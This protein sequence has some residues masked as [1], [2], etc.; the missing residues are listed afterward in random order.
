MLC[1]R[2][3]LPFDKTMQIVLTNLG[4]RSKLNAH[5]HSI[6]L[7][8]HDMIVLKTGFPEF[9]Q[10]TGEVTKPNQDI[11][12]PDKLCRQTR[13]VNYPEVSRTFNLNNPPSQDV[14]LL[15]YGGYTVVRI[16]TS[17]PGN[18]FLH[19]HQTI[20]LLEGMAAVVRVAPEKVKS[21]PPSFQKRC[22]GFSLSS[23]AFQEYVNPKATSS[24]QSLHVPSCACLFFINIFVSLFMTAASVS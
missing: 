23:D 7:H 12:C 19:C 21:P 13:W 3:D 11:Y 17:N 2:A 24:Q 5:H 20:H 16:R 9:N 1:F 4:D 6:H 8:G 14:V 15:P 18:W 22:G 10:S